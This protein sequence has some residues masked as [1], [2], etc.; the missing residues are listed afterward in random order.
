M[1]RKRQK[2]ITQTS[3]FGEYKK[4][5]DRV[6]AAFLHIIHIGGNLVIQRLFGD[7]FDI[8]S[9]EISVIPQSYQKDSIPDGELSC[10]CNYHIYIE[11]KIVCN[12]INESQLSSHK[13]L[14]NTAANQYLIYLTPDENKPDILEKETI[15][16][17]NWNTVIN[18]L[19]GIVAD[20]QSD[21][22]LKYF[23]DQF[24]LLVEHTVYEKA[25]AIPKEQSVIIVGGRFGE[26]VALNYNFYACQPNRTFRPSKYIAFYHQNRIK[27]LFEIVCQKESVDIQKESWVDKSYFDKIEPNYQSCLRKFF[28]LSLVKTFSPEIKNDKTDKN[29]NPTAYVQGQTYTSYNNIMNARTTSDL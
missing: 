12:T 27:Y 21:V 9:N 24:V 6:T 16:W 26:K 17:M 7:V 22:L 29:G 13:K 19:Q 18:R 3:I 15:E 28:Q 11:S 20:G 25:Y 10:E 2:T 4:P 8:P 1:N 14:S 5:E 23:I